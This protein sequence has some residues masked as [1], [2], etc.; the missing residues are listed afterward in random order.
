M[1]YIYCLLPS[2]RILIPQRKRFF[3]FSFINTCQVVSKHFFIKQGL[4]CP[5]IWT[6]K[7]KLIV[8]IVEIKEGRRRLFWII[9]GFKSSLTNF[10]R[11]TSLNIKHTAIVIMMVYLFRLVLMPKGR[12]RELNLLSSPHTGY[13]AWWMW[14]PIVGIVP[15]T[16]KIPLLI[17]FVPVSNYLEDFSSFYGQFVKLQSLLKADYMYDSTYNWKSW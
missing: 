9:C 13:L 1:Y 8:K 2:T 6:Y 3:P 10:F 7:F 14:C 17:L 16:L 4:I 11:N 12:K 5:S 15:L